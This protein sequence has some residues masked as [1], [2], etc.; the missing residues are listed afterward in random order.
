MPRS[1]ESIGEACGA[2]AAF[3]Q[4]LKR[5]HG[6]SPAA[7]RRQAGETAAATEV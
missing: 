4:A 7:C 2:R 1:I 5:V 3:G 6:T